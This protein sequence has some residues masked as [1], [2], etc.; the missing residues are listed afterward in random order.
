MT[1]IQ[2]TNL[3]LTVITILV[4]VLWSVQ[5][6]ERWRYAAAILLVLLHILIFYVFKLLEYVG[7]FIPPFEDFFTL[8]SSYV[9]THLLISTLIS[10]CIL[11]E[12]RKLWKT[13]KK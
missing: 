5:E 9:R 8:W 7:I 1:S 10:F 2:D 6:K 12:W 3:V 11:I 4:V 13:P